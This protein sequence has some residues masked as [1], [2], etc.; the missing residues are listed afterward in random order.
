MKAAVIT[1]FGDVEGLEIRDVAAPPEPVADQVRVRVKAAALNRADLLQRRGRYPAPPGVS[2]EIPGLEFA[3]AVDSIGNEVR[4]WQAGQRVFGITAGAAQ[5]EY[6]LV[7]ANHLAEIPNE[8]DWTM[9]AAVPEAFITAHDAIFTQGSLQL[10]ETLL[11]HAAGSGVGIAAVQL[12]HAAG[13]RVFGTSRSMWKLER[14]KPY[15][16]SESIVVAED[17][18]IIVE[19][20]RDWTNGKGVDCLLDL[21][22]AAYLEVN[23]NSLS[24]KGKMLLV[25]TTSG[26]RAT[27][28]Y[29]LVMGKRLKI[30]GTVLRARSAEE[31]VTATRLFATKVVPLLARGV[32]KPVVDSTFKL[33]Q[34]REAHL[35][36][37]SNETF[38]KVVLVMD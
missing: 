10:G 23:L 17:T 2:Q 1:K 27:L 32:V 22:G 19:Q 3:G 28:D 26:A 38:G 35:R 18:S 11:V 36:L 16:L 21:V 20:I 12:A 9:A 33:D 7:P 37:E 14:A 34:I 8:L 15:G 5:A 24:L 6:V 30:I 13:A 31:K 29:G 25:G 4:D